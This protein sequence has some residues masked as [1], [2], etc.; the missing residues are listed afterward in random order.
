MKPAARLTVI[1]L[2]VTDIRR[3]IAFYEALGFA[4]KF[5]ATGE[6]VAFFD[7]GGVVLGLFPWDQLA[8]DATQAMQ[9]VPIA[10]RGMTLAWNCSDVAEVN[11]VLAH[12]GAQGAALVKPA[13]ETD[14]GG[15][16]GYFADPDCHLWEVVTAPGIVVGPDGRVSLPD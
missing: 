15:Y 8:A 2:G 1:T 11:A 7:A 12:A 13:H 4:R 10:F 3:S 9:P 5:R 14:Y 6:A 16:A